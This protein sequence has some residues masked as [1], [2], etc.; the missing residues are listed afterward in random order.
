M[1][2]ASGTVFAI[3]STRTLIPGR[4]CPWPFGACTHTS[5]VVLVVSR[6]GLTMVTLPMTGT[7]SG[8]ITFAASP[9][10]I[11]DASSCETCVFA[12]TCVVSITVTTGAPD[13][14]ISPG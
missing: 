1:T 12:I 11:R 13:C 6:A 14:G 7:L 10:A 9:A 5:T 8:P 4:S 2:S 3:I